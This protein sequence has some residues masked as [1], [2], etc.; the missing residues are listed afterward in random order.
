MSLGATLTASLLAVLE[1]PSTWALALIAFLVRGGWLLVLAPIVVL[2]TAVGLA[3]VV[4]PILE[5]VAFGRRTEGLVALLGAIASG[6]VVWLLGG[7]LLAAAAEVEGVRRVAVDT[8][9]A[10][11]VPAAAARRPGRAWRVLA[12]RLVAHVPFLIALVWAVIRIAM[13]GYRELTVPSDVAIPAAWRIVTGAPDAVIGVVVTWLFGET[14]G[15]M[16]ARRIVLVGEDAR[17]AS[18]ATLRRVAAAPGRPLGLT[19]VSTSVLV[20]VIAIT[21]I[22]A[23]VA[24]D[25]LRAALALD[26]PGPD[27]LPLVIVFVALFVGGLVLVGLAAAWRSAIWTVDASTDLGGTFGGGG[28]TQSGD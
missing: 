24:W 10:G 23:G 13:V 26:D 8:G 21:G 6:V 3:N 1:R 28:G 20:A 15:A 17:M 14:F 2:P 18:L 19:L 11:R 16:A 22:A 5:D 25:G 9:S 7:G 27:T 4:A 12:A